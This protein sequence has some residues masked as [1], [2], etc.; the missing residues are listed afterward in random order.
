MNFDR[1]VNDVAPD[2]LDILRH[3]SSSVSKQTSRAL[4]LR[5]SIPHDLTRT[6][7]PARSHHVQQARDDLHVHLIPKRTRNKV[8]RAERADDLPAEALFETEHAPQRVILVEF[9]RRA[10]QI[11]NRRS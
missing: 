8:P 7:F 11:V 5:G 1:A 3:S 4:R 10:P 2:R 9:I 6:R